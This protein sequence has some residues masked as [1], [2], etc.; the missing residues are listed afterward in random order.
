MIEK[1]DNLLGSWA[2]HCDGTDCHME[3]LARDEDEVVD[4][5]KASG[6]ALDGP[7]HTCPD[8]VAGNNPA[9]ALKNPPQ[10]QPAQPGQ[11]PA[12][13]VEMQEDISGI[14]DAGDAVEM[15]RNPSSA[16][17]EG[18]NGEPTSVED[19][20]VASLFQGSPAEPGPKAEPYVPFDKRSGATLS[21]ITAK[22]EDMETPEVEMKRKAREKRERA[23]VQ[24]SRGESLQKTREAMGGVTDLL[25]D[26]DG[27][28]GGSKTTWDDD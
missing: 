22:A 16:S 5:A 25:S 14:G 19:A 4:I 12:M 15:T 24:K 21:D 8:C 18:D 17:L 11:Q 6:W 2:I 9:E 28:F 1:R 7:K 20:V 10:Q 27:M 3:V 26:F 23:R 13:A